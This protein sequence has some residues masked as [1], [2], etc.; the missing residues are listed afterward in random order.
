MLV[1][2]PLVSSHT[3]RVVAGL[4]PATPIT[5]AVNRDPREKPAGDT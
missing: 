5:F 2:F 1:L 4:V 3:L